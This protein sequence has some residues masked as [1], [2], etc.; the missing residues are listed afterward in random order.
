MKLDFP[1][2]VSHLSQVQGELKT[3]AIS[4]EQEDFVLV[5]SKLPVLAHPC[6]ILSPYLQA[7]KL[8]QSSDECWKRGKNALQ[9]RVGLVAQATVTKQSWGLYRESDKT[10][11]QTCPAP[12]TPN[13]N[14][15]KSWLFE[16]WYPLHPFHVKSPCYRDFKGVGVLARLHAHF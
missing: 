4:S 16:E 14:L 9:Q 11:S 13:G 2:S 15:L 3:T 6:D 8:S 10:G 7:A 1:L 12:L 5:T